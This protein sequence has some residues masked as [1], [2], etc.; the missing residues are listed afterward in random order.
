MAIDLKKCDQIC[1]GCVKGYKGKHGNKQKFNISCGGIP[2]EY[3]A[4]KV[5]ATLGPEDA[6]AAVSMLD[7]VTWAADVLDWHCVDPDGEV[8]KRKSE[9][10]SLPQGCPNFYDNPDAN[11]LRVVNGKSPFNRP[12]QAEM[13]RCSAAYKV[14]RIGRQAGK[15]EALV[16]SM[17]YAIFTNYNFKVV[18]LA[19]FQAQI[20]M[21][22]TRI[23]EH[24]ESNP[25][26]FNSKKRLVAAPNYELE[27]YNGSYIRGFTAGTSSKGD[28]ASARGQTAHMLVFDEADYLS[29]ADISSVLATV[30]NNPEAT[31]WMSSTPSGK[32]ETFYDTCHSPLYKE[33]YYPSSVNPN[34]TAQAD[35]LFKEQ[36]TQIEYEH[37]I[38]A[39]FGQQEQGVFQVQYVEHAQTEEYEYAQRKRDHGWQYCIGVDWNDVKVGT[40]IVVTGWN[41]HKQR[42]EL[43]TR[44]TVARAGWNQ[45]AA[46]QEIIN[47]NRIW[48]PEYIY[49]DRGYGATQH[50]ILRKY[51]QDA[52]NNKNK[53]PLHIDARLANR[54]KQYD[55]G[56]QLEIRD[57][58]TK[59]P[60]KKHAKPFLVE[61]TVRKFETGVLVF[62]KSD[63]Q[64]EA[65]LLGYIIDRITITGVP[66]YKQGNEKAGD[67][68]LDALMLSLV[69]FE[70]EFTGFGK[71]K[72][73]AEIAFSGHFG[74]RVDPPLYEGE[75]MI[76]QDPVRARQQRSQE[77]KPNLG[78][79]IELEEKTNILPKNSDKLPAT[80][81]TTHD[82]EIGTWSWPGFGRDAPR[83]TRSK[84]P[85]KSDPP[86][87]KKF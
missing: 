25:V 2:L 86:K 75:Q 70:L 10:D 22:F 11:E 23:K 61:N 17:L 72:F 51:G 60:I 66:V 13:L 65:E 68:T 63:D 52:L 71:P 77:H 31:V 12:Y 35:A 42:F 21:I 82:A 20:N 26:L 59:Q 50:E 3:I 46:C 73:S 40:T 4:P 39:E 16:I 9:E 28:A 78:R 34:W 76:K 38:L 36:Y 55:F 7:P 32:R 69:G 84:G 54:V 19:P 37:E 81:T 47:M 62:P 8:W 33:F 79:A 67:H 56:S 83:P 48:I 58:H 49:I 45:L 85:K 14:F 30:T 64:L 29:A 57:L 41:P 53:G 80:N 1:F 15:T 74:D 18:L 27:L 6:K 5:L 87:R 44:K 24:L 43:V